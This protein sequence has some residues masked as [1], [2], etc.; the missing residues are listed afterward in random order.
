M[1]VRAIGVA[2]ALCAGIGFGYFYV[3]EWVPLFHTGG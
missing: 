1:I 2:V 3:H